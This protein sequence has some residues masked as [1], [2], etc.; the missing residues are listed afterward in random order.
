MDSVRKE[1]QGPGKG[2]INKA[3][4]ELWLIIY[5]TVKLP[6]PVKS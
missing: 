5:R 4:R 3:T 2:F 6:D 1:S